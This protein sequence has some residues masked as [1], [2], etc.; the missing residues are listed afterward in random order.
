MA[1][2]VRKYESA[3]FLCT[4]QFTDSK[5]SNPLKVLRLVM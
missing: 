4:P 5:S 1:E 3:A 2:M